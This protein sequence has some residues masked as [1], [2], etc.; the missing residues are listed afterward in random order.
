M[1]NPRPAR[2]DMKGSSSTHSLFEKVAFVSDP[3]QW[4]F[5]RVVCRGQCHKNA[6]GQTAP[7]ITRRAWSGNRSGTLI[8]SPGKGGSANVE[9]FPVGFFLFYPGVVHTTVLPNSPECTQL[10]SYKKDRR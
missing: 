4:L 10:Y 3:D 8:G 9:N 1:T 5:G 2:P 7:I 6:T